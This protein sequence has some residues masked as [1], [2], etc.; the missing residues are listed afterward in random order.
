MPLIINIVY[1]QKNN[2]MIKKLLFAV[3]CICSMSL[4]AQ[5][6]QPKMGTVN[7]QEIFMQMP[8][9]TTAEKTLQE[10]NKKYEDEFLKIQEEFAR[11]YEEFQALGDTVPETIRARRIQE[12]QDAQ[13]RIEQFREMATQDIQKQQETLFAP[14]QQ[15]LMEA[16]KAVGSEGG[17]TY[18]LDLNTV[19]YAGGNSEDVTPLVKAKLGLGTP[20]VK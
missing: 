11:K 13:A 4:M 18:I 15:K 10:I 17:Y 5:A 2:S 9:K 1:K 14:I 19:A 12:V 6:Q 7:T 8:E 16:I 3:A 20:S